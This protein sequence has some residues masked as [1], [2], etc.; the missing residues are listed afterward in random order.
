MTY[1]IGGRLFASINSQAK[2]GIWVK[3]NKGRIN[4][5]QLE[6]IDGQNYKKLKREKKYIKFDPSQSSILL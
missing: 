1:E 4:V 3:K 6:K 2:L 5:V